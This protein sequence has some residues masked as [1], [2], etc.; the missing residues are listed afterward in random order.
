MP[1]SEYEI[2]QLLYFHYNDLKPF[3]VEDVLR[4]AKMSLNRNA[5]REEIEKILNMLE[6]NNVISKGSDNEIS[7][8]VKLIRNKCEKCTFVFYLGDSN[9]CPNCGSSLKPLE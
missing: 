3:T 4:K 8:S 2:R 5:T 1:I 6:V 7:L 9:I